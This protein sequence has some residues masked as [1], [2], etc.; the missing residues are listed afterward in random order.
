MALPLL[1]GC[2][3]DPHSDSADM[4][5]ML[6]QSFDTFTGDEGI[7]REQAAAIPYAS[8]GV[9]VGGSAQAMLVLA[10][11]ARNVCLWTSAAHIA[12]ET[13]SGRITRTAGLPH[14]MSQSAFSG[15][16]P[17]QSGLTRRGARCDYVIDLPDRNIFQA[18]VTYEMDAPVPDE[19][20][21][22]GAK[23]AVLHVRER[24]SCSVLDWQFVNEYW[25]DTTSGFI[26]K[27]LQTIHP[28]LDAMEIVVFRRPA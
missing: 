20:V 15:S 4:L 13:Q 8:I 2:S 25:A 17:L 24:G 10:T 6:G 27:S 3:S 21:I 23:L 26:W 14:N 11:Q 22:L 16:D 12:V 9:R 7:P 18:P 1:A 5:K 28:D 19:I